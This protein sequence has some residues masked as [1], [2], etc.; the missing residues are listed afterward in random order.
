MFDV[1]W[2]F[3]GLKLVFEK[4]NFIVRHSWMALRKHHQT[5]SKHFDKFSFT[6]HF[7][8]PVFNNRNNDFFVC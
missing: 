6:I 2:N 5:F 1:R 7:Q 8:N 3:N 4:N